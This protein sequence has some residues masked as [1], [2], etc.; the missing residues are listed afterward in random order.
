M[1]SETRQS[2][3]QQFTFQAEVSQLLNILAHSLY[4]SKEIAVRELISNASDALDKMRH[5]AL[6]D[7]RF[8]DEAPLEIVVERDKESGTLTIRDN[9]IGMTR[10]ELVANLG[11]IA[12]SGSADFLRKL[13]EGAGADVSLIGQFGVGFYSAFMVSDTVRVLTRSYSE[14][15]GWEWESD[16]TGSFTITP[17]EGLERGTRVVLRLKDDVRDFAEPWRIKQ[18][19]QKYSNFVRHPIQLDGEVVNRQ[20]AIWVEP[21]RQVGEE[22]YTQFYQHLAHRDDEKPLWYIHLSVDSPLQFH[23]LVY[24]PPTNYEILGFGRLEHGM[25]LCARRVLV[26]HDCRDLVPEYLR[27]LWGVVDSED[28]SLNVARESLQD[29]KVFQTIRATIV[30][31]VLD[32]LDQLAEKDPKGY[33]GFYR[34]FGRMLKEGAHVD[35]VHRPRLARLLR[36][37][38]SH[39]D[40]PDKPTS[41]DAYVARCGEGQKAIYYLGGPDLT[42]IRNNPNLEIFRKRGIEVLYLIDPIDEFVMSSLGKYQDRPLVPIDE[43]DL[44]LPDEPEKPRDESGE[45]PPRPEDEAE[46]PPGFDR[47]L[48]LFREAL[49]G[50]VEDVR[51]SVRLTDSPCCLVRSE[52]TMSAHMQNLLRSVDRSVPA[53]RLILEVNPSAELIERLSALAAGGGQDDLIRECGRQLHANAL[54]LEGMLPDPQ[55]MAARVQRLMEHLARRVALG[56]SS[57]PAEPAAGD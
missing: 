38:S 39:D 32:R 35:M 6:T 16:G 1:T 50:S 37:L 10:D 33:Q 45:T 43:A 5:L 13:T 8:R 27:F 23:A 14:A 55:A 7:P 41:L 4:Q 47:V 31:S 40:D 12:H 3:K 53:A 56:S 15:S 19:L 34:Q 44:E 21:P 26:Q 48:E 29:R 46:S 57:E 11:T 25:N 20:K 42:A 24:C 17:A 28:L 54:L 36:F 51:R 2:E 49:K 30:R 22:E 52:G 18:I 9:G